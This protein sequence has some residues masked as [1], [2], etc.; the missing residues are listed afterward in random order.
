MGNEFVLIS[1]SAPETQHVEPIQFDYV[2]LRK[3]IK[4]DPDEAI[5][6]NLDSFNR[7]FELQKKQIV[8]EITRALKVEGDRII[9]AGEAGPHDRI[10]DLVWPEVSAFA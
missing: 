2:E 1:T 3:E 7:K 9:K 6:K 10:V 4:S 5:Q 8:E